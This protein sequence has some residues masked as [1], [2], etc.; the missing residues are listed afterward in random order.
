MSTTLVHFGNKS[1]RAR[2]VVIQ[3]LLKNLR[4]S[5]AI[6]HI[7]KLVCIQLLPKI[8]EGLC[9][10]YLRIEE[11]LCFVR[12]VYHGLC[13]KTSNCLPLYRMRRRRLIGVQPFE[14]I[15]NV[16]AKISTTRGQQPGKIKFGKSNF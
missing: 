14:I 1:T 2:Y 9:I 15:N 7:I 6:Q 4:Q 12:P 10:K 5:T 3:T 8:V 16:R 11:R 13:Y